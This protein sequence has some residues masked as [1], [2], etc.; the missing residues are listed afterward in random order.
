MDP[1]GFQGATGKPPE[2]AIQDNYGSESLY[3][4]EEV[5]REQAMSAKIFAY[6]FI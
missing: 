5:K 3:D 4:A 2:A 1:K 6:P